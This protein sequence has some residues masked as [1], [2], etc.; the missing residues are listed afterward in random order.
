M[1]VTSLVVGAFQENCWILHDPVSGEVVLIDPGAEPDRLCDAVAEQGGGLTAIWLT[2]AHL[3]HV[4][5][6]EGV[7]RRFPGVPVHLHPADRPVYD[8]AARVAAGY[9]LPFEQPA[10]PD[11]ELTEGQVVHLGAHAFTIW[12]LP[13]HAPGH[14]AF[15]G[16]DRVFGGDL[17]FA[18]SIGRTDLPLCDRTAMAASLRRLATL[19]PELI[20]HPGH[21][22]STTIGTERAS[23]P[24]LVRG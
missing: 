4:G 6:I 8:H 18:G 12:H 1:Q 7:R 9:G 20:V 5:G 19:P 14:V 11:A 15:I 21:G 22:P 24:Y 17:L 23:N 3:D 2:H 10:P 13:G 16:T